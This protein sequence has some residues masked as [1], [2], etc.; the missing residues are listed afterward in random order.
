M[1]QSYKIFV[2]DAPLYIAQPSESVD[3]NG[4]DDI[5]EKEL[6]DIEAVIKR[7]QSPEAK[8]LLLTADYPDAVYEKLRSDL[9][10]VT[11]A[12]GI[13][14]NKQKELL[15]IFRRGKW[16]LP[17]GKVE[18][19]E[20]IE[21]AAL[22]EVEEEAGVGK[23]RLIQPFATTYHIYNENKVWILK[24]TYW[25]EMLSYDDGNTKPQQSEGITEAHWVKKDNIAEK[26]QNTYGSMKDLIGK[27][28]EKGYTAA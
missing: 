28:L 21:T 20:S 6:T 5:P 7:L 18:D 13:V 10:L 27:V 25:Y 15:M 9:T 11:A 22:R 4:Y 17:K 16:D 1:P 23:L 8:G 3:S 12:G 2:K 19:N 26:L 14:W 24:E